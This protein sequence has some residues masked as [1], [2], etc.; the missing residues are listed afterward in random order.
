M[1]GEE[2]RNQVKCS[3]SAEKVEK[4]WKTKKSEKDGGKVRL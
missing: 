4:M 3:I 1:L 2:K